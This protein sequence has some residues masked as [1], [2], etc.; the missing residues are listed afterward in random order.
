MRGLYYIVLVLFTIKLCSCSGICKE[1]EKTALL[2]LKK[3]ANDP[4]NVLSS[5]V[6]KEDCCN[7]EGVLCHNVTGS[8][9]ELSINGWDWSELKGLKIDDFQWLSSLENLDSL[10]MSGVDLSE[11]TNWT[12]VIS[13]LP[14][15]VNLRFSNCSLHSI[16]PLF[17]HNSSVLENLDLSLNNFGSPIPGWV[18]SFG[19]LV[20]LEFT[21]SNFTGSFPEGPF[22]LTSFTTLRASSNSFGSVLPQ[23]LFDLSNLEYLDLSFS[24][25]EGP[26]PNG[27]GDFTKL[28]YLSL[29]SNNLNST[30]PNGSMDARILKHLS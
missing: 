7:W 8:V 2:R 19:S 4:T 12:E 26:I 10:D 17:D 22:N 28:T 29:A 9:I 16:P 24:G 11:A 6:D 5:W 27:V 20:S 18:F 3:E 23:W 25:L 13:M 1:N 14:S 30:I 21:G 15:L